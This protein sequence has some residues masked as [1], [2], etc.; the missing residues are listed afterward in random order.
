MAN[1]ILLSGM[2][3]SGK[4]TLLKTLKNVFVVAVDG[5]KYP[6][7]QPHTNIDSFSD[8]QELIDTA[9]AKIEI[10]QEK[11]GSLPDTVAIDS[12]SR[13]LTLI[14]DACSTKYTGFAI[15]N[16]S[17][18]QIYKFVSFLDDVVDAGMKV[19]LVS[20]ALY[21]ENSKKYVEVAQGNFGKIGGFLSTV[22]YASFIDVNKKGD[23]IIY[24]RNPS[25][26]SR[27]LIEDIP[28]SEKVEDFNLQTYLDKI[29]KQSKTAI[30][31]EL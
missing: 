30:K 6:F 8:I 14:I 21:D 28:E 17:N 25:M 24:H 23:R 26:M 20:H 22:D 3:N 27:T 4:T 9:E 18:K 15:W 7:E 5:K 13:I 29:S 12:V 16:E 19:V 10:Y 2:A 11:F 31:F 1:K